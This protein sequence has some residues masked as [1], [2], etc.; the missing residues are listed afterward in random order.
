MDEARVR[1]TSL[2]NRVVEALAGANQ[3]QKYYDPQFVAE[4][5]GRYRSIRESLIETG[6][7]IFD[8]API[9]EYVTT[10]GNENSGRGTVSRNWMEVLRTDIEYCLDLV[11]GAE[12][13][14]ERGASILEYAPEYDPP[15]T[16]R[17][18]VSQLFSRRVL[19]DD[20]RRWV[21]SAGESRSPLACIVL[22]ID[23]FKSINET[24]GHD[25]GDEVLLSVSR[26]MRAAVRGKGR[27]YR[28]GAGDE[29][30]VLLRNHTPREAQAVAERIRSEV[31]GL[32]IADLKDGV[33][34][35]MGIASYPTTASSS[36]ELRRNADTAAR[37]AKNAGKNRV[38]VYT[39]PSLVDG[40]RPADT[41]Q[42]ASDEEIL[43]SAEWFKS[44]SADVRRNA[45]REFAALAR[46][47]TVFDR[48]MVPGMVGELLLDEDEE[49]RLE[50]LGIVNALLKWDPVRVGKR[51]K[52]ELVKIA[53]EDSSLKVRAH[54][55]ST[56]GLTGDPEY[57][58]HVYRWMASWTS[59]VPYDHVNVVTA[60][61]GLAVSGHLTTRIR[62]ELRGL[63]EMSISDVSKNRYVEALKQ[64]EL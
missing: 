40:I 64:M 53:E 51:Y 31:E 38:V 30:V 54:A 5:Y 20:L 12:A 14:G 36:D 17:D 44:T 42:V 2:G 35:S 9:H 16:Q 41:I 11:E 15:E 45:V 47:K 39:D 48:E 32:R 13:L 27:A 4:C 43:S 59:P 23:N 26:S 1:L 55:M 46:R 21:A 37:E 3:E 19:D 10:P 22:D 7:D 25:K 34:V 56:I 52:R 57:L 24:R 50:S 29:L 62:R 18:D 28:W 61:R 60:L 33:T 49:V 58:E 6:R 63:I 8:D